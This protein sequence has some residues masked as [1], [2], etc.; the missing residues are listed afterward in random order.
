[1]QCLDEQK[2]ENNQIIKNPKKYGTCTH[3]ITCSYY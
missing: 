3:E 1:M 2:P